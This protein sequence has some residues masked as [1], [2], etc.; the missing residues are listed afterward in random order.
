MF[1]P[2]QVPFLINNPAHRD[3]QILS[4]RI[5]QHP[6][7]QFRERITFRRNQSE[8]MGVVHHDDRRMLTRGIRFRAVRES[9]HR[10]K[11]TPRILSTMFNL[12]L[13]QSHIVPARRLPRQLGLDQQRRAINRNRPVN[14]MCVIPLERPPRIKIVKS[15]NIPD[16]GLELFPDS[17]NPTSALCTAR[18][19]DSVHSFVHS[20]PLKSIVTH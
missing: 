12:L 5:L 14:L 13:K 15:R 17:R 3:K 8:Q 9:R 7:E 16:P 1:S 2:S 18:A 11:Q 6:C 10:Y 4:G 20:Y 19:G